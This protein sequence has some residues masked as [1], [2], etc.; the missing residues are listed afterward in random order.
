MWS[1]QHDQYQYLTNFHLRTSTW[2]TREQP[3][4]TPRSSAVCIRR[5][6]WLNMNGS[7]ELNL[8]PEESRRRTSNVRYIFYR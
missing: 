5:K 6:A 2:Y 3:G 1:A 7:K 8:P 4:Y